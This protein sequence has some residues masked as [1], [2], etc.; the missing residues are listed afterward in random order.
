MIFNSACAQREKS[1]FC[2]RIKGKQIM[3]SKQLK[4]F[5]Q[6]SGQQVTALS[7]GAM[8]LPKDTDKAIM[9]LRRAIDRGLC[10]IDTSRGYGESE[11]VVGRA[12]KD[13]YRDK[14][15][16]STKWSPWITKIDENDDSSSDCT[17]RRNELCR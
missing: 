8:R 12:L 13:G 17:R 10:Y 3:L 11:L 4:N 2:K 7:I 14:V 6:R 15:I 5:G 1:S 16:L 9:L